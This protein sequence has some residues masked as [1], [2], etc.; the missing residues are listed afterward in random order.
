MTNTL[1]DFCEFDNSWKIKWYNLLR[2][3]EKENH[4]MQKKTRIFQVGLA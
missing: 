3:Y 1:D 4:E 2:K